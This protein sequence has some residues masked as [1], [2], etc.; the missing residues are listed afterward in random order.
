M[1]VYIA[2]NIGGDFIQVKGF[3]AVEKPKTYQ[4][5][6]NGTWRRAI[7]K[8]EIGEPSVEFA[9]GF[10]LTAEQAVDAFRKSAEL[11][12]DNYQRKVDFYD[13]LAKLSVAEKK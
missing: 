3:E 5:V 12:R 10:G 8:D 13:R 2:E 1:K 4:I 6:D 9:H 11:I 7:R